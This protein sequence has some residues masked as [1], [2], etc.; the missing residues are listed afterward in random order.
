[1][2]TTMAY[3]LGALAGVFAW[4]LSRHIRRPRNFRDYQV[5]DDDQGGM[6][7]TATVTERDHLYRLRDRKVCRPYWDNF[8]R[9]EDTRQ[10]TPELVV[11]RM[12]NAHVTK[13]VE[14]N[15]EINP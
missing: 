13:I 6:Y 9:Y 12:E 2:T 14:T 8:W 10:Y 1:M 11:E 5:S 15:K 4:R 3:F 7:L